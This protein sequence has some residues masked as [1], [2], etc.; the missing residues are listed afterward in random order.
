MG[1]VFDTGGSGTETLEAEGGEENAS[2][3]TPGKKVD[4]TV[5]E[6]GGESAA[7]GGAEA[8]KAEGD[9]GTENGEAGENEGGGD[10]VEA[11][12]AFDAAKVIEE[13]RTEI[14]GM[15]EQ[16][17]RPPQAPQAQQPAKPMTEEEWV[18]LESEVGVPRAAIQR[19]TSQ[20]MQV[21]NSLKE[22]IDSKFTMIE[23]AEGL[24]QVARDPEFSDGL[25]FEKDVQKYLS[26]VDPR[27]RS[28]PDVIK[29]AIIYSRGL[30]YKKTVST[31]RNENE[32]N[33]KI[34]GP[35]RPAAPGGG[36]KGKGS[37]PL[38][39]IEHQAREAVGWTEEQYRDAKKMKG[40]G[41]AVFE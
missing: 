19:F 21:A 36:M 14:A 31:V 27:Y 33:R 35:A 26:R 4:E 40:K 32:K 2:E 10:A 17:S 24:R 3:I 41:K 9:A 12:P 18:S 6:Q 37:V 34:A 38:T 30:N 22:Y 39:P 25:K 16:M 7:D 13:L 23:Q 15:K 29:D 8:G 1:K 11:S 28:N 20:T 5:I